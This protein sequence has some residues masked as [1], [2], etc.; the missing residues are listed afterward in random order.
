[1]S[2][3][4]RLPAFIAAPG[5]VRVARIAGRSPNSR[6]VARASAAANPKIRQ[7]SESATKTRFDVGRQEADQELAEPHGDGGAARRADGR[8]QQ[9]FGQHLPD[10]ASSRCA[11]RQPDGDLALADGCPREHQVREIG[12]G[13]EQHDAG[14]REQQP[15]RR[16]VVAAER[17]HAIAGSERAQLEVEIALASSAP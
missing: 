11:N 13:D 9:A 1:M 4:P 15:Q 7:S 16:L 2:V 3:D 6:H 10:D 5:G 14:G 12:A 17:R 8:K